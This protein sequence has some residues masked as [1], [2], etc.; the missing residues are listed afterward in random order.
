MPT[1]DARRILLKATFAFLAGSALL[2]VTYGGVVPDGK[3][4][5][6]LKVLGMVLVVVAVGLALRYRKSTVASK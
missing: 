4:D 3:M 1:N 2:G 6:L 5:S